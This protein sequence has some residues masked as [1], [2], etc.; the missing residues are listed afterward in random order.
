[1]TN[2]GNENLCA[3]SEQAKRRAK[4][5]KARMKEL[6][7]EMPLTHAYEALASSCGFRNW[8]TMKAQ[9]TTS[10]GVVASFVDD[11]DVKLTGHEKSIMKL[12]AEGHVTLVYGPPGKGKTVLA[13]AL[14]LAAVKEAVSRR[15][16]LPMMGIVDVGHSTGGFIEALKEILPAD[17]RDKIQIFDVK[18][19][20]P[21]V[22]NPFDLPLGFRMPTDERITTLTNFLVSMAFGKMERQARPSSLFVNTVRSLYDRFSDQS[23]IAPKP[24]TTIQNRSL[25]ARILEKTGKRYVDGQVTWWSIVNDLI[26]VGEFDLAE[27]AQRYAVPTMEDFRSAMFERLEQ[28]DVSLD[29][30]H[31]ARYNITD[32]MMKC[33]FICGYTSTDIGRAKIAV[34]NLGALLQKERDAAVARTAFYAARLSLCR[35]V[36]MAPAAWSRMDSKLQGYHHRNLEGR[37]SSGVHIVYDELQRYQEGVQLNALFADEMA[38]EIKLAK[39]SGVS[40]KLMSQTSS[41]FGRQAALWATGIVLLDVSTSRRYTIAHD[42][43]ISEEFIDKVG[44]LLTGPATGRLTMAIYTGVE[45]GSDSIVNLNLNSSA[46]WAISPWG[47]ES[48]VRTRLAKRVGF[49]RAVIALGK[50][51]PTLTAHYYIEA[52][53]RRLAAESSEY[54]YRDM[55]EPVT[56][57][58]ISELAAVA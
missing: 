43:G 45:N 24:Y 19:D 33:K 16:E 35:D 9:F 57:S 49:K 20:S 7:Y 58:L 46:L 40:L 17:R 34:I 1:M 15:R 13:N 22:L 39:R 4:T 36:Y 12:T 52:E 25:A 53:A 42:L 47:S 41:S 6:G 37:R 14:Y 5:I 50:R 54:S 11:L 10:S 30:A 51:F 55:V 23:Q 18:P 8:P 32:H 44:P 31:L 48:D 26:E 3:D 2:L 27:I 38:S 56:E 21:L 29:I 28:P